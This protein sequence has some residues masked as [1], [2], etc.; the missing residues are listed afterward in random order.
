M[1]NDQPTTDAPDAEGDNAMTTEDALIIDEIIVD[2]SAADATDEVEFDVVD[3]DDF[4][5]EAAR[6]PAPSA[7]DRPG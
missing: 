3:A 6:T 2:D 7:Y 1:P 4:L 5:D